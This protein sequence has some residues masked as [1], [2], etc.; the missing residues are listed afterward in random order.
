MILWLDTETFNTVDLPTA[1]TY[2]YAETCE[3]MLVPYAID[4]GPVQLWDRTVSEEWPEDLWSALYNNKCTIVAHHAMF[5][6]NIVKHSLGLEPPR[7]NW[8]CTMTQA[9]CHGFPGG[10]DVLGS[11]LGLG[12]DHKKIADGKRLIHKFCKPAPKNHKVERYDRVN[13]PKDWQLFC[14]YAV[15]DVAAMR[16]VYKKLPTWNFRERDRALFHLDQRINDRGFFVDKDLTAAAVD[17]RGDEKQNLIDRCAELTGGVVERPTMREELKKFLNA[18]FGYTLTDTK[19]KTF[20]ALIPSADPIARELMEISIA[21]NKNSTAKYAA[22]QEATSADGRFRGGLQCAGAARTRRW[23]GRKFQAQNLPSRGIPKPESIEAY[24]DALKAGCHEMLFDNLMLYS[25]AALRGTVLAPEGQKLVVSDLSN[26]EGR[27]NAW[28]ADET[29]K[30]EAFAAFDRGEGPDLYSVTA[31]EILG[32]PPHEVTKSER[33]IMGK[34]PELAL[35]YQGGVGAFQTFAQVYGVRMVDHW[36]TIQSSFGSGANVY[37]DDGIWE[38]FPSYME[39]AED[40]WRKWGEE[41]NADTLPKEEWIASETVKVAWRTK[42]LRIRR[43]W[44]ACEEAAIKA[45]NNSGT[46]YRAGKHLTFKAVSYEGCNYLLVRMPSGNFMV[47]FDPRVSEDGNISY[48][49][50]DS[51][52]TGGSFGKWQRIHTYGGKLVENICQSC[53]RDVLAWNM[54]EAERRGYEIILTVHDELVTETPD[55]EDFT[56]EEL[57]AIMADNPPWA[58]GLPLAAAGYEAKRYK[59]DD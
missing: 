55:T 52:A 35:G 13:S 50:V 1:G 45:I 12:A 44:Y 15:R 53:S 25:S 58:G 51:A 59:K 4:D 20:E 47:Y 18:E 54:P 16:E 42:N 29:W 48:M 2:R 49:G 9:Y 3:V 57:S 28:L 8:W 17:A 7:E 32:K 26:I 36:A 10:L 27:M 41:R 24:I 34:V 14:D 5:D 21:S 46:A 39:V 23:A 37:M 40:N 56:H 31:G 19:A 6:R 30:L 22:L 38:Y 43:L 33:N 11:I